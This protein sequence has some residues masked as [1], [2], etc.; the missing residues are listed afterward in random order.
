LLQ[1]K[2]NTA[3]DSLLGRWEGIAYF[4]STR[5]ELFCELSKKG[6]FILARLVSKNYHTHLGSELEAQ[7]KGFFW[8]PGRYAAKV[9]LK[10]LPSALEAEAWLGLAPLRPGTEGM[11][12]EFD[13]VYKGRPEIHRVR[14]TQ[15]GKDKIR[16]VYIFLDPLRKPIETSGEMM[17]SNRQSP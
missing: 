8:S 9:L 14:F 1:D 12:R 3:F 10:E 7:F 16:Y 17:R 13:L 6:K 11:D 5:Y 4:G 2:R 15:V